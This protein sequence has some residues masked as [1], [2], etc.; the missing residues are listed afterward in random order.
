MKL[1]RVLLATIVFL[2]SLQLTAQDLIYRKNGKIIP[3]RILSTTDRSLSYKLDEQADNKTYF[4]NFSL[5]DSIVYQSGKKDNFLSEPDTPP[6][7]NYK[8]NKDYNHHLIGLDVASYLF[9][10][11]LSFSYEF[12]PGK[13]HIGYKLVF[14]KNLDPRSYYSMY[15]R[16]DFNI[17]SSWSTRIGMN[18][19][20]FPPRTF[21][22]GTGLHY[23][24]GPSSSEIYLYNN[25]DPNYT[26]ISEDEM[27][28]GLILSLFAFYNINNN[29]AINLGTDI[30][31]QS[32]PP[33]NLAIRC[34]ILL[35]F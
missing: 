23:M 5:I 15:N 31:L 28:H 13:A 24:F 2:A 30:F 9:Y 6:S 33:A 32:R 14:A 1:N 26:I 17:I 22:F 20:M 25:Y 8:P 16:S 27:I 7:R 18:L 19:Y 4:L 35:N 10:R 11:N 21:R 29:L 34:E 12:L 3:A